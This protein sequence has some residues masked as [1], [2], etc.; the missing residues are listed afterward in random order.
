MPTNPLSPDVDYGDNPL[1]QAPSWAQAGAWHLQNLRDTWQ[2][3]QDAETWKEAARQYGQG[4]L[5]GSIAPGEPPI[6]IPRRL[7]DIGGGQR[8]MMAVP[9]LRNLTPAEASVAAASE[10]HI[11]PKPGNEGGYVGAPDWVK[12]PEDLQKMRD[13]LDAAIDKG[14]EG[15][16]WYARARDWISSVTGEPWDVETGTYTGTG[17]N[18]LPTEARRTAEGLG[19]FSPQSDPGT[20]LQFQLQARNAYASGNPLDLVRTGEQAAKY[21]TGMAAKEA[22]EAAGEPEPDIRQGPKTGPFAWHLSPDRPYGTT[23]V[24]DIWHARS[25]G[26]KDPNGDEFSGSPTPQQHMFMDYETV[27]AI[28]RANARE[29]GGFADWNAASIQAAP[30]VANKMEGLRRQYPKWSEDKIRET[31]LK[32]FPDFALGNTAY[33]PHE[34]VPGQSTGL[35]DVLS[36]AYRTDFS[37]EAT[38]ADPTTGRDLLTSPM[39]LQAPMAQTQG[40]FI[41]STGQFEANPAY[42]SNPLVDFLRKDKGN[43]PREIAPWTQSALTTSSGVRGLLDFQEGSPWHY[44]DTSA[45]QRVADASSMRLTGAQ[46]TLDQLEA[47][48]RVADKHGYAVSDTGNGVSLINI[49]RTQADIDA[50]NAP[51]DALPSPAEGTEQKARLKAGMQSEINQAI[52][53]ATITPGRSSGNYYDLADELAYS[54]RGQG[55]ATTKVLGDLENLRT[56]APRW[57]DALMDNPAIATKAQD[58]LDRLQ[59]YGMQK[60]RPDYV[61]FLK[62]VAN[63]GLRDLLAKVQK[64][65]AVGLPAALAALAPREED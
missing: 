57:Y 53:G 62:I 38:W 65:G 10:P 42:T 61:K 7:A 34:Q 9:S 36:P 55:R 47:L 44:I 3:M 56:A 13:D 52:P 50:G 29:A 60:A 16:D 19:V 54:V 35:L 58:N 41:N 22:A 51:K 31:A 23:G 14:A 59:K 43:D 8:G 27:L 45:G 37:K 39:F 21:N 33:M 26:Y 24:N 40:T 46:P 17:R 12:T 6:P 2:A 32:T 5:F 15:R 48:Q 11:I 64:T 28:D 4:M 30:W 25:F 18:S 1:V 63:G 20:N 49:G